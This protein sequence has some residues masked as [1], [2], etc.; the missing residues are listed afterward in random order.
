MS[1]ILVVDDEANIVELLKFN[2]E[3]E[4]FKVLSAGDGITGLTM[5][6]E[7]LPDLIILDIMMP[8][9]DGFEVCR[10]LRANPKTAV[11]PII[12][13]SAKGELM[14]KVIGLE[15]GA[16]DY[17]T[18]PFSPRELLARV[19]ANLRR[20]E[21]VQKTTA[22]GSEKEIK[23][24]NMIIRPERFE[25]ILEGTRLDLSPKEF[26]ILLVLASNPG[27]VFSRD[28]LLEKI[29]GFD[30]IRE[31]R[32][33]DVHIRYLRQKIERDPANPEFIETVRGVG[34]RFSDKLKA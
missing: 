9:K 17:I 20:Q 3:K 23:H 25:A 26:E 7:Y 27:R 31:T 21:Y 22:P 8:D 5:A 19:K 29:W 18:K 28:V 30:A 10:A 15:M 13:L 24:N 16:D 11:V 32:T 4:N 34:Y 1:M 6:Q 14:D 12:M 33:V 2:L